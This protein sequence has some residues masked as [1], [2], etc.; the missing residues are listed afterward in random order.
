MADPSLIENGRAFLERHVRG[1]PGQFEA[2]RTWTALLRC[3]PREISEAMTGLDTYGEAL[4][5]SAPVF[6]VLSRD[7]VALLWE[8]SS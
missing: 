6:C 8:P 1:D 3:S 4:R 5:A 2:Y 7:E